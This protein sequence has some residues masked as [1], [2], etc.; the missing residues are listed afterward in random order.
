V[1]KHPVQ[2]L[3]EKQGIRTFA[4]TGRIDSKKCLGAYCTLGG[5]LRAVSFAASYFDKEYMEFNQFIYDI[6][7]ATNNALGTGRLFYWPSIDHVENT[8]VKISVT[9]VRE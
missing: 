4:Y 6:A 5:L 3:L 2:I 7:G 9:S 1:K 8:S